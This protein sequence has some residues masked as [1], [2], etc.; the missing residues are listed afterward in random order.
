M[1]A[2]SLGAR[3]WS[4]FWR[5]IWPLSLP[6]VQAGTVIVWILAFSAYVIPVLL[7]GSK[8]ITAPVLVVQTIL[9]Q[10]NWPLGTAQASVLFLVM[11]TV[12]LL[13]TA[14]IHRSVRKWG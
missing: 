12:I 1:A 5:I 11:A 4:T 3:G 10:G 14:L 7:G 8:V 6:G 9:D 13:Y 2:R